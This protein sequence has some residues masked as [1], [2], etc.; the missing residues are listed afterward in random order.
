MAA[1]LP[2]R[3][4]GMLGEAAGFALLAAISPTALLV[5]AVFLSSASPR[6]A[7]LMYVAGAMLMTVAMAV[8]VLYVLRAAGLNQPRQHDPRY[9]LRLGLGVLALIAVGVIAV[10][11]QN[12]A[13][14][15][16]SEKGLM[17]RI[18]ARPTAL[19]AFV[20]GVVLFTPSA[21]FIAA[22]QVVATANADV[23]VTVL[24]L[25]IVVVVTVLIV[26]LPLVA[27]LAAP[28]ATTRR[29]N[30]LNGWL[31]VRGRMLAIGV[32]TIAGIVLIVN[33]ALG[34]AGVL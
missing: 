21:T 23:P 13:G 15:S 26:W 8:A 16:G 1:L 27:Y 12:A 31:R 17:S 4:T 22:V 25:V 11:G 10:R 30:L 6:Q 20:A 19:A 5:M 14:G 18:V 28:D 7:A 34:L 24:A 2:R 29:L 9:G 32:L 33:G 3:V